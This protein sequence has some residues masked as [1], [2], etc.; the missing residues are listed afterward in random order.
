MRPSVAFG[1]LMVPLAAGAAIGLGIARPH[2]L[3]VEIARGGASF[4]VGSGP[5]RPL[6]GT[7]TVDADGRLRLAVSNR[8]TVD[9]LVGVVVAPAG[10]TTLVPAEYCTSSRDGGSTVVVVR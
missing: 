9:R 8:D 6:P 1:L 5:A 3:A 4:R 7:L 10:R 2:D